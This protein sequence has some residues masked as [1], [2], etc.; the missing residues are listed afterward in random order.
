MRVARLPKPKRTTD[1][2]QPLFEAISNSIHAV[3]DKY[4]T[5]VSARG[6]IDVIIEKA[7][8]RRPITITIADNGIGLDKKHYKAFT[9]TDTGNKISIGGKGVG[10]LL[11]LDCFETI[12]VES[13]YLSE[14]KKLRK[15]SFR[16]C[17][18]LAEQI[19]DYVDE[20]AD[21]TE[22]GTQIVFS[23]LR[24]N[25]Y[26]DKFPTRLGHIFRHITSHFLPTFIGTTCPTIN[27]T[28]EDETRIYPQEIDSHI[29]RR[30]EI[31]KIG[32]RL[33]GAMHFIML[34]C[35]RVASAD[36]QGNHFIHFIAHDR[37]VKSQPIDG[38]LGFKF[39]G[40]NGAHVFHGCLFGD[41]LD[42][43]VNQERTDFTFEDSVIDDIVNDVCMPYIEKFLARPI[44]DHISKQATLVQK[45]TDTYPSVAFGSIKELQKHVPL[46]ELH[47]DAI[48]GHLSR[49]RYR[50]DDRQARKIREVLTRLRGGTI[51]PS[52]FS[53]VISEASKAL[54]DAER[55]S[56]A[57]YVVRRKAVLDL[58]E[59]L[60]QKV[61]TDVRD[62]SY[63]REDVLHTFICPMQV[64]NLT[65]GREGSKR[66]IS[67]ASHD[68]WI[69]DER[70]TFAQYFSSD[71]S[72]ADLSDAFDSDERPDVLIFNRVHGLRQSPDSSRVL[73]VEFKRPG[74]SDYDEDENPQLQIE[75]YVK[76][77]L[78]GRELDL[79]GR[80]VRLDQNTVFYCYIVA[81]RVGRLEDW[82]FSWSKTADGRGRIYQPR[83]GFQGSIELIE[84][85]ALLRDARERNS[86]FFEYAGISGESFFTA[87]NEEVLAK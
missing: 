87:T 8:G 45:I 4:K 14:E 15:R 66:E 35:D 41:F 38:R 54:E 30:E 27:V 60:I 73:L 48:Y 67:A 25:Q 13:I 19:Q 46:G 42:K 26:E 86:A 28:C 51:D 5:K 37:T 59:L 62:S 43:H 24:A 55:K 75:R 11:W 50:R 20:R 47:D 17:L 36:L 40:E 81:D 80:P 74:R 56:L 71:I 76:R 23:G 69:L 72:F 18:A 57:E 21:A 7:R 32:T 65:S 29:F 53:K 1:A 16:F 3:Q 10:R 70:L 78:S 77:L 49:E 39:F 61:R 33:F 63:Q 34:E 52:T 2:L 84:W 83:D 79:R 64:N 31:P 58:L 82:T 44:R 6:R 12:R 22:T 85:D 68:L 9:T